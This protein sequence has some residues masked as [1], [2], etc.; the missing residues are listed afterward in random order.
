[1]QHRLVARHDLGK[2]EV[3]APTS[4]SWSFGVHVS[5]FHVKP[6]CG[7]VIDGKEDVHDDITDAHPPCQEVV[8]HE[9]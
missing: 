2:M 1:M 8:S 9:G 7:S 3:E 5:V 4:K 6:D